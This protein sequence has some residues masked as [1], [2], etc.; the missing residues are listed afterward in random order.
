MRLNDLF[1]ISKFL[2]PIRKDYGQNFI[3]DKSLILKIQN[4][5]KDIKDR[6]VIEIGG[7][8]GVL[9]AA[10]LELEPK[11]FLVI[12]KDTYYSEFLSK[13]FPEVNILNASCLEVDIKTDVLL[14]NLPYNISHDFFL[15]LYS[16]IECNQ[17]YI[18]VQKE[19]GESLCA[20]EGKVYKALSV[21]IQSI[22]SIKILFPVSNTVFYPSPKVQSVF[23]S[24]TKKSDSTVPNKKN[25]FMEFV[26]KLFRNRRKKIK[27]T[28]KKIPMDKRPEELS[29]NEFIELFNSVSQ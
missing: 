18:M 6:D 16:N 20:K 3:H 25:D 27:S 26:M 23:L 13:H 5:I 2:G 29:V 28:F 12:E 7:G 22:F 1:P 10:I 15:K 11:S 14:S 4:H 24:L 9:T 19:F 8:I 17:C 21:L